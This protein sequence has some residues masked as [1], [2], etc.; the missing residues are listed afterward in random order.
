MRCRKLSGKYRLSFLIG[1]QLS[2]IVLLA[3]QI[4][5]G[6]FW[7]ANYVAKN[8]H[9]SDCISCRQC[10]KHCPQHLSIVDSLKEVAKT[11]DT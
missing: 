9:A 3:S 1:V 8:G 7:Y 10:E 4:S 6:T 5:D 11:F 2:L